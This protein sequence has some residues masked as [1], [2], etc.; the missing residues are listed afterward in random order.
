[1]TRTE[2]TIK[3]KMDWLAQATNEELLNQLIGM[4]KRTCGEYYGELGEDL[5]ITKAEI[6]KRMSR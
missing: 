3:E 6:L 1:M 2:L 4:E 5:R